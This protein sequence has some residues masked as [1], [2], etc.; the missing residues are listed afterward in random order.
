M[1]STTPIHTSC[2]LFLGQSSPHLNVYLV[3][4]DNVVWV[5]QSGNSGQLGKMQRLHRCL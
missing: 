5:D 1:S 3:L 2:T 4:E